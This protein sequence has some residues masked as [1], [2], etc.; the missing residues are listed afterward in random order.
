MDGQ[1]EKLRKKLSKKI[2]GTS[3]KIPLAEAK[4]T[5]E[6]GA[7]KIIIGTGQIGYI[8]LLKNARKFFQNKDLKAKL[9]HTPK[10]I[11]LWNKI[12][13]KVIAMSHVTC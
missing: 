7:E 5:Y 10:A 1:I 13:V 6:K 11:K 2:N 12:K 4:Y 8:E 3:H 9:F